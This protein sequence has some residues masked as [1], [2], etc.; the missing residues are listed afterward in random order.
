M[1]IQLGV[2]DFKTES[3]SAIDVKA[4][5]NDLCKAA[6]V[7]IGMQERSERILPEAFSEKMIHRDVSLVGKNDIEWDY[8]YECSGIDEP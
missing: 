4:V 5:K 1:F 7:Q 2:I 8:E 3:T 6:V